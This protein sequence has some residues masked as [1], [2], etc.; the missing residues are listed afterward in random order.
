MTWAKKIKHGGHSGETTQ[1]QLVGFQE[2][3][4]IQAFTINLEGSQR[5]NDKLEKKKQ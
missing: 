4:L 3:L 2:I 1:K 5:Q